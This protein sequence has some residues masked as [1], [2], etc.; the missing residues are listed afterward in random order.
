MLDSHSPALPAKPA[1]LALPKKNAAGAAQVSDA[2]RV[3]NKVR[4]RAY[5]LYEGRG[6]EPGKDKQDWLQAEREVLKRRS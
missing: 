5:Q 1:T 6:S 2:A 4:E 3:E